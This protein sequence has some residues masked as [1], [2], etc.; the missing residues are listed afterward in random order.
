MRLEVCLSDTFVVEGGQRQFAE[1]VREASRAG[2]R[3][4]V[5]QSTVGH[6]TVGGVFDLLI[7][8]FGEARYQCVHHYC[9]DKKGLMQ[10]S[11]AFH[12]FAANQTQIAE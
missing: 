11:L 5:L 10:I 3:R 6:R 2:E 1:F 4:V 12:L 8:F 9:L 7:A